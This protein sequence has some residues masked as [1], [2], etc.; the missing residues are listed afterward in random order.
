MLIINYLCIHSSHNVSQQVGANRFKLA[1]TD[2]GS[3]FGNHDC[4][5]QALVGFAV[6]ILKAGVV[7]VRDRF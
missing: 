5:G 7:Y 2:T 4:K 1:S 6:L 3:R